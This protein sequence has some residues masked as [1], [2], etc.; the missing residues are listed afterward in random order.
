MREGH[1]PRFIFIRRV[2]ATLVSAVLFGLI[3]IVAHIALKTDVGDDIL[4]SKYIIE[5]VDENWKTLP[6]ALRDP[7]STLTPYSTKSETPKSYWP[8]K[9]SLTQL[10]RYGWVSVF[11]LVSAFLFGALWYRFMNGS[12]G[13][14][15]M[16]LIYR[17]QDDTPIN[18][19]KA[20][21]LSGT[22]MLLI[23]GI[24]SHWLVLILFGAR[25]HHFWTFIAYVTIGVWFLA[26]ARSR[27]AIGFP[28]TQSQF[29]RS[30]GVAMIDSF[31]RRRSI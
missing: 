12:L 31:S 2:V 23:M 10:H 9:V 20:A 15:A 6:K 18:W 16:R 8:K 30:A 27:A 14:R 22:D 4:F 17:D 5:I 13:M 28:G 7:R 25:L 3:N 26:F 29:D 21:L 24:N 1:Q 11:V 19:R